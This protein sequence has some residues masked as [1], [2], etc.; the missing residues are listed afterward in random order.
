MGDLGCRR[1][2]PGLDLEPI[3]LALVDDLAVQVEERG[4][5]GIGVHALG[6]HPLIKFVTQKSKWATPRMR[7]SSGAMA[8][9]LWV[10]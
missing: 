8:M 7:V 5:S 6:Y 3:P 1:N 9:A 10:R 2:P 4:D